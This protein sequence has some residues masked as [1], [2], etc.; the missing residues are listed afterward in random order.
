MKRKQSLA[1]KCTVIVIITYILITVISSVFLTSLLQTRITTETEKNC[2]SLTNAYAES[3]GAKISKIGGQLTGYTV[4][5]VIQEGDFNKILPWFIENRHLRPAN[6]D[7]IAYVNTEGIMYSDSAVYTD[8]KDTD[9]FNEII[10]KKHI[11]YASTSITS[12]TTNKTSMYICKA[13]VVD[14]YTVGIIANGVN[15]SIIQEAFDQFDSYDG[16]AVVTCGTDF[17]ASSSNKKE[18]Y[19]IL[20][21]DNVILSENNF[22]KWIKVKETGEEYFV[23]AS[24]IEGSNWVLNY[25]APR[26]SITSLGKTFTITQIETSVVLIILITILIILIIGKSLKP[27]KA[28]SKSIK[29]IASGNADLTQRI[30]VSGSKRDEVGQVVEGFNTFTEKLQSIMAAIKVSKE[31]LSSTG[32]NLISSTSATS[33]A[34]AQVTNIIDNVGHSIESQNSNV[35]NSTETINQISNKISVLNKMV[36]G[37]VDSVSQASSSVEEMLGNINSVKESVETMSNAFS[38]LNEKSSDS[39]AKQ[40]IVFELI[41]EVE[42]ESKILIQANTVISTI[43]SQTNLLAMNAAIEAAHAGESGKGFSVVADEIRKLSENSSVQTKTIGKQLEKISGTITNVVNNSQEAQLA[44]SSVFEE[45]SQTD[46]LVQEITR[47]MIEQEA[48]S[49]QIIEALRIM[50]DSTNQVSSAT[51]EMNNDTQK[52]Y[53][54]VNE[55]KDAS[56]SM[57]EA[58]K[59]MADGV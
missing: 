49:K 2:Y 4:S 20:L 1:F 38:V 41:K 33:S 11:D 55:L 43:A 42:N 28:V 18:G 51:G 16:Y 22:G 45:L 24:K 15:S 21:Q 57:K 9:F 59:E 52:I 30:S 31:K 29:E 6:S 26:S 19:E 3:I 54:Q 25:I 50:N 8:V 27:L 58:M 17:I 56:Q 32:N 37:Q 5:E 35:E 48:G 46:S 36:E 39:I 40:N 34:I 13:V 14:G 23:T 12:S 44:S 47:A 7:F 10:K 53:E